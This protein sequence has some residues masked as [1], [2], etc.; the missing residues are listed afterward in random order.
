MSLHQVGIPGGVELVVI[1][2][3]SVIVLLIPL[4]VSVFIYRDASERNSEHAL[5]WGAGAFLTAILGGFLGGVV[6]WVRYFVV[7]DEVGPGGSIPR[8]TGR[9]RLE[10]PLQEPAVP[11]FLGE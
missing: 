7:R 1:L 11:V 8:K 3:I 9:T 2:L 6:V 5:A 4:V 10:E